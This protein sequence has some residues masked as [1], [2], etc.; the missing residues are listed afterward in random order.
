MINESMRQLYEEKLYRGH[1]IDEKFLDVVNKGENH[2]CHLS[3]EELIEKCKE[4]IW[5]FFDAIKCD[6][7]EGLNVDKFNMNLLNYKQIVN[8]MNKKSVIYDIPFYSHTNNLQF[9]FIIYQVLFQGYK[10]EDF[11]IFYDE[12]IETKEEF[13]MN[14]YN[15]VCEFFGLKSDVNHYPKFYNTLYMSNESVTNA[16]RGCN[17][18]YVFINTCNEKADLVIKQLIPLIDMSE[19]NGG[20]STFMIK[21]NK[22][23]NTKSPLLPIVKYS[24]ND[25][26]TKDSMKDVNAHLFE[27]SEYNKIIKRY[28]YSDEINWL[29]LQNYTIDSN[30]LS[31]ARNNLKG[32]N[33]TMMLDN[34]KIVIGKVIR[35]TDKAIHIVNQNYDYDENYLNLI[36]DKIAVLYCKYEVDNEN[37]EIIIDEITSVKLEI[38]GGK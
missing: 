11:K 31:N 33:I 3:R 2:I 37:N 26:Y 21:Y 13:F 10:G 24:Y 12:H 23:I 32:K 9:A 28:K 5:F 30:S 36:K 8:L 15:R 34:D 18:P 22:Y 20:K 38:E 35:L 6:L 19:K 17:V 1:R 29:L 25:I 14:A 16:C 4:N 27:L 7:C